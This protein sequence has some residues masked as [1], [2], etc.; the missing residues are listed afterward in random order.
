MD[1]LSLLVERLAQGR[2]HDPFQVLG[3]HPIDS[4]WQ[5]RAWLPTAQNVKLADTYPM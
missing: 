5:V 4:G 1:I 3:A 2:L